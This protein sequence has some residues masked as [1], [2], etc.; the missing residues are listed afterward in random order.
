MCC[1]F[2]IPGAFA[3][4]WRLETSI[5]SPPLMSSSWV[6]PPFPTQVPQ[7]PWESL[8]THSLL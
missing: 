2:H 8:G 4:G 3:V 6:C 1:L 7:P 5:R